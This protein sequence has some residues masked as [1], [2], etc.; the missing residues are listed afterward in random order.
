[1]PNVGRFTAPLIDLDTFHIFEDF[2]IEQTDLSFTDVITDSGTATVGDWENGQIEL[3]PSDGTV[4]DN[5]ECSIGATNE[6][7]LV[8][9]SR[10]IYGRTRISYAEQ[11]TDDANV[12]FGF[13]NAFNA[14]NIIV[15]D[16]G[17]P[18]ASGN[19]FVIEKRDGETEWRLTTR[20]G[21]AVTTTLSSHTAGVTTAQT[22]WQTLEIFIFDLDGGTNVEVCAKV[23]GM[24]LRDTNGVVITHRRLIAS[25][26]EMN[27]GVACKNGSANNEL[28]YVDYLYGSQ[29]PR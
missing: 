6:N 2:W 3:D 19:L 22:G 8:E 9:A 29:N 7:F 21:T 4:A 23:D 28:I 10:V 12:M 11:A 14:A 25:S 5:D 13:A 16:G 17:G 27:F 20:N 15:D 24:Y 26:T 18:R 1:M